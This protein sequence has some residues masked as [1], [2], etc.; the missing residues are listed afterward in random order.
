MDILLVED[1]L[2]DVGLHRLREACVDIFTVRDKHT[3]PPTV[4]V[5]DSWRV[6]F[7]ELARENGF[8]PEDIDGAAAALTTLIA[9]IE[10][11][12]EPE[13]VESAEAPVS[14]WLA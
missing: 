4:T 12:N 8:T 10:A 3:W 11:A 6:P 1:L 5:Y 14:R 2:Y 7:V 13:S 9:A